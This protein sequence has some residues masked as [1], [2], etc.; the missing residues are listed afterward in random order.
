MKTLY[1][2]GNHFFNRFSNLE[3]AVER[4]EHDDVIEICKDLKDVKAYINKNITINGNGHTIT[5]MD[6]KT[7]L[8]C[9]SYVTVKQTRFDCK[10]RTNAVIIRKGGNL[11]DI[12]TRVIGPARAVYPTVVQR[13]GDLVISR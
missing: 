13:G 3:A 5:P 4:A 1:V 11:S 2:G 10:P 7:A 8:D 9:A 6:G 12:K